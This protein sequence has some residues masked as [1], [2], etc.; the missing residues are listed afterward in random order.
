MFTN[1][2]FRL[3]GH[4]THL[5]RRITLKTIIFALLLT[6]ALS[7]CTSA[8][9]TIE[10]S[11]PTAVMP[12][13]APVPADTETSPTEIA[14]LPAEP[15]VAP[16]SLVVVGNSIPFNSSADCRGCTGFVD[17]YAADII[18]ATGHPVE[19]QNLSQHNNLQI[20]N[21]IDELKT[22]T[23][24]RE[25]LSNADIIIVSIAHND[26]AWNRNDDP[27]DGASGDP[28][29]S[30][31]DT[32][33]AAAAAEIFRPKF[34]SVFSQIAQLRA[35]KPTIFLTLNA[36]N[37]WIGISGVPSEAKEPTR[38]VLDAWSAMICEAA[39]AN[40]FTCADIYHAF[41]GPDGGTTSGDLL[42]PDTVHP[43]DK[44]NEVIAQVLVDLGFA[45]LMP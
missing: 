37:D 7:A 39:Q 35:G 26:T 17:R 40:G 22:D 29:W 16:W 38:V 3:Q 12:T 15:A 2:S 25:A 42:A 43:S 10:A 31:Y 1:R 13:V 24:R 44:G 18:A 23:K 20:D 33:C 41:N 21:L 19:V 8:V 32:T 27:C 36:Y 4:P 45:P 34:E 9:A 6:L 5:S 28:D 30:K 14:L 11:T